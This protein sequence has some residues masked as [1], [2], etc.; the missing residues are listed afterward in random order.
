MPRKNALSLG[1]KPLIAWS[2]EQ[3]RKSKFLDDVIVSTDNEEIA[4]ISRAHGAKVP[5]VRPNELATDTSE[6]IDVVLHALDQLETNGEG[7]GIV[8]LLEPTSPLRESLDIDGA[9]EKLT[10]TSGAESIVGIAA[11]EATH[12]TFLFRERNGFLTSYLGTNATGVR[13]QDLEKLHYL[14]G[15]IYA[16]YT[17]SLRARRSFYHER[18]IGWCVPRYKALEIDEMSDLIVCEAL[19]AAR[20]DGKIP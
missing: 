16:A 10:T 8:V 17:D 15:S 20:R 2:I 19:L 4:D 1:G 7:Y 3:A 5:F 12:P 13:R 11:V 14:E 9:L 18:T 6:T